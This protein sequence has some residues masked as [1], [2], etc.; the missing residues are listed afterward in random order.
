[1]SARTDVDFETVEAQRIAR[2]VIEGSDRDL[3]WRDAGYSSPMEAARVLVGTDASG[4][5]AEIAAE[6]VAL[7]LYGYVK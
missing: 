4:D 3:G 2:R 7:D 5:V 1:M 6:Q